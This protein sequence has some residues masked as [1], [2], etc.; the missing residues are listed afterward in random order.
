MRRCLRWIV[1][2]KLILQSPCEHTHGQ[3]QGGDDPQ[4]IERPSCGPTVHSHPHK[5][6]SLAHSADATHDCACP[7]MEPSNYL[8]VQSRKSV[9]PSRYPLLP[10]MTIPVNTA[11]FEE[12]VVHHA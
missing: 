7:V 2:G 10:D 6:R 1:K 11:A 12:T 9:A 3:S 8:T 5:N 4:E